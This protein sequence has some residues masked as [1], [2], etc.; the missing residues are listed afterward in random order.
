MDEAK[1]SANFK[2]YLGKTDFLF[3]VR[4]DETPAQHLDSVITYVATCDEKGFRDEP[5]RAE[6]GL[7]ENEEAWP[8]SGYI[9]GPAKNKDGST[10]Y[11]LWMYG[12][13]KW[14]T[15]SIYHEKWDRLWFHPNT[16]RVWPV[17][18]APEAD[19]ARQSD[20]FIEVPERKVVLQRYTNREGKEV[21]AFDRV[22]SG[23]AAPS[24]PVAAP[25]QNGEQLVEQ[26]IGAVQTSATTPDLL[27]RYGEKA[28]AKRHEIGESWPR[29]QRVF[30]SKAVAIRHQ[31]TGAAMLA[32]IEKLRPLLGEQQYAD[33]VGS[34]D[35]QDEIHF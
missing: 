33:L 10:S 16:S 26:I 9:V 32:A 11:V 30:A 25:S 27:V 18:Q 7:A 35:P 21:R 23:T 28:M 14:K 3:T 6:T 15:A 8:V 17:N 2:R 24:A 31:N 12:R 4:S 20:A 1:F 29:I 22:H 19:V 13:G 34:F 5:V